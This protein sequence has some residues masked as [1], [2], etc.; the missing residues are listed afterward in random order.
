MLAVDTVLPPRCVV[1]GEV[2]DR[3]GTL[4]PRVWAEMRFIADPCC[5]VC[6]YPFDFE[7]EKGAL[8]GACL[9]NRPPYE[10]ARAALRYD[11]KSRPLILAFKHGDKTHIVQAFVP[12][13]KSAGA[14]MLA[15]ADL[16]VPVPLHRWRLL[17]RRYNQSALLALGLG[18]QCGIAV[19]A[20]AL[21]RVRA[22]PPQGRL[23]ARQRQK[24]VRRAFSLDPRRLSQV[25]GKRIV[26][27]D[28]VYTTGATVKECAST[29]LKAGAERVDVL[30]VAR[31]VKEGG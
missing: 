27:V 19:C 22:T 9:E 10:T 3:Q 1:S 4:A 26:L 11:D 23:N 18:R 28:D 2:V 21:R 5:A 16:L 31:V 7:V 12:W 8:C 13:L 6:G 20:D 17:G 14:E 30:C 25:R 24:N 29:L 15:Q